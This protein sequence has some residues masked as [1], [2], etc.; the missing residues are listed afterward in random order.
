MRRGLTH[1]EA[2]CFLDASPRLVFSVWSGPNV[3][4]A[5]CGGACTEEPCWY[6]S[7]AGSSL[8]S[9]AGPPPLC[10]T[11]AYR[12]HK[13]DV[14]HICGVTS[15]K[16]Q[17]QDRRP[18]RLRIPSKRHGCPG[19]WHGCAAHL[20]WRQDLH[21]YS[22]SLTCRPI[23]MITTIH[24][25]SLQPL[26]GSIVPFLKTRCSYQIAASTVQSPVSTRLMSP[27]QSPV[28]NNSGERQFP[29]DRSR[30]A[31]FKSGEV[32]AQCGRWVRL[33]AMFAKYRAGVRR[34]IVVLRG[35][36]NQFR[37]AMLALW[38]RWAGC[39]RANLSVSGWSR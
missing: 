21:I 36:D 30:I 37:C 12:P 28:C 18:S 6:N 31:L 11:L 20:P 26:L 38:W 22:H 10:N 2:S 7:R 23:C 33:Y 34:A 29:W 39:R 14:L 17:F 13:A 1:S 5:H 15:R 27:R 16:L 32:A 3:M 8:E 35:V 25:I 9:V 19:R 4:G 24:S